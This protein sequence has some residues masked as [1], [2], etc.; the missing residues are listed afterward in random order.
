[1][2]FQVGAILCELQNDDI[3]IVRKFSF[4]FCLMAV[5]E[6]AL[7]LSTLSLKRGWLMNMCLH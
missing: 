7:Q 3:A 4:L 6:E 5:T 2:R 1:M